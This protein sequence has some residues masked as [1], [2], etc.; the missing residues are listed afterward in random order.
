MENLMK[1]LVSIESVLKDVKNNQKK[2]SLRHNALKDN[3]SS[4]SS[5]NASNLLL[6]PEMSR[7]NAPDGIS[8]SNKDDHKNIYQ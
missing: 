2:I 4:A 3:P 7:P 8:E 6:M 1:T 5:K